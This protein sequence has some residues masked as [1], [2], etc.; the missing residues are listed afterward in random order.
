M[1]LIGATTEN[2]YFEVN[3]AL[4]SRT[5]IYEL[6]PH[7]VEHAARGHPP[8]RGRARRRASRDEVEELIARRAGGDARNALTILEL[9]VETARAEG[10]EL[11]RAH[12]DDAARKRPLA[13]DKGGDAPLRLHLGLDQVDARGRRAG[14][15][16]LPRRDAR[17]RR[18]RTLH[19]APDDRARLRGHRQRR[20]AGAPRRGRGGAG[21]RARRPA[22]GAPQPRAGR[23]LPRARAEVER[24]VRRAQRGDER[25]ARARPPA[26]RRR[27]CA[28]RP[29]P[30]RGSSAAARATSTRTTTRRASRSTACRTSCRGRVYYEPSGIGASTSTGRHA[31]ARVRLEDARAERA[32]GELDGELRGLVLAVEDRVHLD[33][34]ERVEQ[35]GLGDAARARGAPRGRRGRR[36]PACRH[37]AR[38]SGRPR[39]GRG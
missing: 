25:R 36:A 6:E 30:A 29:T 26:C 1:T 20:P 35:A 23:R 10:V 18:G 34:L 7:S 8:R 17:G 13:Y 9:A 24:V 3:S 5:Q 39:R 19:R 14:V 4:L 11:E 16:L 31:A 27:R 2:P 37:R 22:G 21:G 33:E 12:V 38:T 32:R 15:R 28:R